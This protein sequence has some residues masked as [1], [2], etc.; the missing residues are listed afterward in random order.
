LPNDVLR[1]TKKTRRTLLFCAIL[2]FII[3]APFLI[4]WSQGI[5]FDFERKR[6]VKTGGIFVQSLLPDVEVYLNG[7]FKEKI[8]GLKKYAL[9][10][11]LLPK[12]YKVEVKKTGYFLWTKNLKVKE[13]KVTKTAPIILFKKEP[14][15]SIIAENVTNFF[16]SE[17][18][19]K[20]LLKREKDKEQV[21]SLLD[22]SSLEQNEVFSTSTLSGF[23]IKQWNEAQKVILF[24][25]NS[26]KKFAVLYYDNPREVR[27]VFFS[28]PYSAQKLLLNPL[29]PKE[30]F[31]LK[32]NKIF[33]MDLTKQ[34]SLV[35]LSNV[36]DYEIKSHNIYALNPSGF[37]S[38]IN[39]EKNSFQKQIIN[40]VPLSL[41]N[42]SSGFKEDNFK[43]IISG[44]DTFLK[45]NQTLY[46]LDKKK[47]VF[48]EIFS[49]FNDFT[50]DPFSKR[51]AL[52]NNQEIWIVF[53][54][55]PSSSFFLT[56]LSVSPSSLFWLNS[57]YLLFLAGNKIKISEL[58]TRDGLNTII[59]KEFD[60]PK[61]FFSQITKR[62][63]VLSNKSLFMSEKLIP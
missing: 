1:M 12:T 38:K 7:R 49:P 10:K 58:D 21:F 52:W 43:V 31:F 59:L 53:P 15:F 61:I 42:S 3:S 17:N 54:Y 19:K 4:L 60:N 40:T 39:L 30:L 20:I 26:F 13:G 46:V 34:K 9:L 23:S 29:N 8:G 36:R 48:Q 5:K 32:N 14:S 51:L 16:V 57:D 11:N 47:K 56:R 62:L 45:F 27:V 37:V 28:L 35:F 22:I 2:I 55:L 18:K 24:E 50:K 41:N 25:N 33:L 6:F 63:Y 44:E